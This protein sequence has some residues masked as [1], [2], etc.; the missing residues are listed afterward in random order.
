LVAMISGAIGIHM[1]MAIGGADMPVVV[2]MLNSYS[3]WSAAMAGFML[4]NN[5]LLVTGALVGSSG[6]ILSYIMCKGMNR[7]FINVIAGG[8]GV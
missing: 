3:G 8:W 5:L 7:P 6:A 2:S 4:G 1:I